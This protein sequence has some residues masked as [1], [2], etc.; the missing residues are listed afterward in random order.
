ML[1]GLL[2]M[3][4]PVVYLLILNDV[5]GPGEM[6]KH[7]NGRALVV[8]SATMGWRWLLVQNG[9]GTCFKC[10]DIMVGVGHWYRVSGR[11]TDVYWWKVCDQLMRGL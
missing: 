5:G 6:C 3:W 2:M 10:S 11:R 1:F 4:T 8:S 7:L 9:C